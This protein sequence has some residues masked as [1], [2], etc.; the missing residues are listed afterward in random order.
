M[1]DYLYDSTVLIDYLRGNPIVRDYIQI[2]IDQPRAVT[3]SVMTEAELWAGV[4]NREDEQRHRD[5]LSRMKRLTVSSRVARLGGH[6]YG[7]Y[8]HQGLSLADALIAATAQVHKQKLVTRNAKHF[9]VVQQYVDL[10]FY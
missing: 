7:Q 5:L 2:L 8:R 9:R 6:Y 3:Y 4:R 10:E 1:A